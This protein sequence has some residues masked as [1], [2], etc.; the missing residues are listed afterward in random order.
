M[1]H[2]TLTPH[3]VADNPAHA[4]CELLG[5]PIAEI[6]AAGGTL[7]AR[8][9]NV[10]FRTAR[11]L[12][13]GLRRLGRDRRRRTTGPARLARRA[14]PPSGRKK[15][16]GPRPTLPRPTSRYDADENDAPAVEPVEQPEP[17]PAF[18]QNADV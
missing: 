18:H 17:S 12:Q 11:D 5:T 10:L 16:A 9:L 13:A 8:V 1:N 15:A 6:V 2:T 3:A 7:A 14:R 4:G